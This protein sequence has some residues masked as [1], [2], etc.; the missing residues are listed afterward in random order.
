MLQ[1][2]GLI[3]V[4]FSSEQI[5]FLTNMSGKV[6]EG[7]KEEVNDVTDVWTFKKDTQSNNPNWFVSSTELN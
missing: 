7:S 5:N 4:K 3:T 6:I 1:N 2:F